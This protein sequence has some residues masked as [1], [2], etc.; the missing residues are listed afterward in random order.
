MIEILPLPL[1]ERC[2][3]CFFCLV[4]A[5]LDSAVAAKLELFENFFGPPP[6]QPAVRR[7]AGAET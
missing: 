4:A 5:K 3:P 1:L 7:L 6:H 2:Q